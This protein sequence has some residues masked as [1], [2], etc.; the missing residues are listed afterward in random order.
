MRLSRARRALKASIRTALGKIGLEPVRHDTAIYDARGLT[1]D[2]IEAASRA[3][4]RPFLIDVPTEN[5]R[6]MPGA[7]FACAAGVGN[8]F[9]DTLAQYAAGRLTGY[10]GSP[11]NDFHRQWQPQ[12]AVKVLGVGPQGLGNGLETAGPFGMIMPFS[13][14]S[15]QDAERRWRQMIENDNIEHAISGDAA[16]G[17]KGWGPVSLELGEAEIVRLTRVFASIS[18]RGYVRNDTRDGD[19]KGVV[20]F[21][22]K[23]FRIMI[24]GGHHRA[25]ALA[26]LGHATAPVR[27]DHP[28][29]RRAEVIHWPAVTSGYFDPGAALAVFDRIF[30]GRQPWSLI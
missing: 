9:V 28:I 6:I 30:A 20:L 15:P 26:V 11:L 17:W 1:T 29:A 16:M 13:P 8:P 27:I 14:Q 19:I 21:D 3:G 10:S 24:T 2:P 23:D 12:S 7:A 22:G 18:E 25:A 5:C 4:L